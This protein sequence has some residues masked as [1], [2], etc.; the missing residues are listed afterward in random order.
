[1]LQT[2]PSPTTAR[3][4]TGAKLPAYVF[5]SAK[6]LA[7]RVAGIIVGVIHERNALGQSAVLGL[8]TGSTPVG[9]Y[10][11]LIRLHQEEGVDFSNVVTFNLDEYYGIHPDRSQSY[12]RWMRE[13]LFDHINIPP[14][15][16]HIPDGTLPPEEVSA[17][18]DSYEAKIQQAGGIDVMLLGIGRNGHIGFNEPFS[19]R[20]SRTR[21][22][23]LD[24][25]T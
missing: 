19:V 5:D 14:E 6:D 16:I 24:P 15:N 11:A 3:L 25:V 21:L 1:M 22:C 18:C 12:Q 4:V 13:H 20:N 9:V 2:P 23:T 17:F 8:P 7:R 10:R